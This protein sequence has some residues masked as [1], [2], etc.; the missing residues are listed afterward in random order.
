[1]IDNDSRKL[2]CISFLVNIYTQ[3]IFSLPFLWTFSIAYKYLLYYVDDKCSW[4]CNK[5]L[6]NHTLHKK[7]TRMDWEYSSNTTR[8]NMHF[9]NHRSLKTRLPNIIAYAKYTS[10]LPNESIRALPVCSGDRKKM[11]Q[12]RNSCKRLVLFCHLVKADEQPTMIMMI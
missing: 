3:E 10:E 5:L 9:I 11:T 7:T 6:P 4:A 12:N 1:M 8:I 2:L